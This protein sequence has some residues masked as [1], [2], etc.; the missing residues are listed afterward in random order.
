MNER[1]MV[2]IGFIIGL[3]PTFGLLWAVMARYESRIAD[4]DT[5]F[6]FLIGIFAGIAVIVSHLFFAVAYSI[7]FAGIIA[8]FGLGLSE[9]L[10][11]YIYLNRSKTK[12]RPDKPFLGLGFG[13]GVA[14]MYIAFLMGQLFINVDYNTSK[15]L[16]MIVF[17][18]AVSLVRGSIGILMARTNQR[19]GM[20]RF[21]LTGTGILGVFNVMTFMYLFPESPFL[22]TF[23][24][25][26]VIYGLIVFYLFF[27]DLGYTKKFI[28]EDDG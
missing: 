17:A 11:Y 16:G 4:K 26:A 15:I 27:Q 13:L 6:S 14:S 28:P 1:I 7:T 10:L 9:C 12:N 8:A 2:L 21:T 24:I 18:L 5:N 19:K 20:F 23:S 22:Y 3:G 25:P